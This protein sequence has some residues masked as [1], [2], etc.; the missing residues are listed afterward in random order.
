MSI[1]SCNSF[2]FFFSVEHVVLVIMYIFVS[3]NIKYKC[4]YEKGKELLILY[5]DV[6]EMDN[7]YV[8][9]YDCPTGDAGKSFWPK[10]LSRSWGQDT[11]DCMTD[12]YSNK[13]WASVVLF[14]ETAFIPQ[15][16]VAIAAVC[17]YKNY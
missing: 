14:V 16:A 5:T 12:A 13:G 15:T 4:N 1:Y 6:E 3:L 10:V 7:G 8:F 2:L 9:S 11:M 17:A